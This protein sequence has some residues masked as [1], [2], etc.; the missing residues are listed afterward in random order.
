MRGGFESECCVM[1]AHEVVGSVYIIKEIIVIDS[2]YMINKCKLVRETCSWVF[3][4]CSNVKIN[5]DKIQALADK[6]SYTPFNSFDHHVLTH[7]KNNEEDTLLYLFTLDSLNFCFWP[8]EGFEY[9]HLA[10]SVKAYIEKG[11]AI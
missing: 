6:F 2:T 8:L 4:Q 11:G 1:I 7:N 5:R 3:H 9:E 10:A